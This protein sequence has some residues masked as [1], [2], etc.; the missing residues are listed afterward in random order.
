MKK[1]TTSVTLKEP[2]STAVQRQQQVVVVTMI[3]TDA[4]VETRAVMGFQRAFVTKRESGS[5][6]AR[7]APDQSPTAAATD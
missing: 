6:V 1:A 7:F 4:A 5:V 2:P 3:T